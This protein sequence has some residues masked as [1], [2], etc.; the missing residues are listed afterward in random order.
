MAD[1]NNNQFEQP[2]ENT[3]QYYQA[4]PQQNG[5]YNQFNGNMPP[6]PPQEEKANVGLAILSFLIPIV[7][8]VL[9]LTQKNEKPKTAKAC[10]KAAL[11]CVIISVI[12]SIISGVASVFLTAKYMEEGSADTSYLEEY[13]NYEDILN[14][15]NAE[16][17]IDEIEE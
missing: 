13:D 3:Q 9:Y 11:A 17:D 4:P 2:Q 5:Y 16:N 7:G 1:E 10:G 8:L 6:M 12:V 14:S 15:F